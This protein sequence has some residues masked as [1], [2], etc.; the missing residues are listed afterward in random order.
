MAKATR[1]AY[2]EALKKLAANN[3]NVV[4]L[5][6]DLSGSTK[7]AE[8]KKV[9]PE[10]FFNV[11]IAEQN[12]IGT[13]AGMS[14]AGKIPFASSFA[15]FAAGRA[16]EIIRNTVA[17][18]FLNVKI[19]A[20][21]A[22]LTVGEDGA[23]HQ[24]IEDISLMRSIPNMTVINPADC[25]EAEQAVLKAAEYVGPVYIRLGRMAVEDV[26]DS[27]YQFEIGKGVELKNGSDVTIIAT[28]IMVQKALK[29]AESL[30]AQGIDA[31]VINIH[32]IKPI[33]KEIIIKA[34][35]ETRAIVTAEEHSIIGGLGSAVLEVLSDT[36]PVPVR[37]IGVMDTFGESGKPEDLMEKYMLTEKNIEDSCKEIIKMK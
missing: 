37:R 29:A 15:M 2:G 12:L 27:S 28:G 24:A 14:L 8:F 13:A 25:I 33:D 18:P 17:Y 23:S 31:R 10:R 36:C 32:T 6:A 5:D 11:G 19:A 34:A 1:E 20:T 22:G 35:K 9:S 4:V 16:F 21:H 3:P 26:Y 7:T 30:K